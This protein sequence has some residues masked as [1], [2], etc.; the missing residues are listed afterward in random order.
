MQYIAQPCNTALVDQSVA[1]SR[2]A[3]VCSAREQHAHR[4]QGLTARRRWEDDGGSRV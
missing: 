2:L 4:A 1:N 3:W